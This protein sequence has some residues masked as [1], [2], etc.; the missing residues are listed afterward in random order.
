MNMGVENDDF[1]GGNFYMNI[2]TGSDPNN[3]NS[4]EYTERRDKIDPNTS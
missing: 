3:Q 1:N 4:I 2:Y